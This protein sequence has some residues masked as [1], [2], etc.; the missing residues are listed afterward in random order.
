MIQEIRTKNLGDGLLSKIQFKLVFTLLKYSVK[1]K[2]NGTEP[3]KKIT[4]NPQ[5]N[6]NLISL[7]KDFDIRDVIESLVKKIEE[8]NSVQSGYIY[9]GFNT[10]QINI[11]NYKPLSGS[12]WCELPE[13]LQKI[14][15]STFINILNVKSNFSQD[16]ELNKKINEDAYFI[17]CY[18]FHK[19]KKIFEEE[20]TILLCMRIIVWLTK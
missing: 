17:Y 8:N 10:F 2:P 9:F 4:L 20:T 14:G 15:A 18:A 6:I 16:T 13:E 1:E 11:F 19:Y 3:A 5:T 7:E 12:S